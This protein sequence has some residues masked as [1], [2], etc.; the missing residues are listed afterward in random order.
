MGLIVASFRLSLANGW[1]DQPFGTTDSIAGQHAGFNY[2][3][4]NLSPLLIATVSLA[5]LKPRKK[6]QHS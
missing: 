2:H 3:P 6:R 1:E 5:C 4:P